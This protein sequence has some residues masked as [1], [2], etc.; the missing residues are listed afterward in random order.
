MTGFI[1]KVVLQPSEFVTAQ[2]RRSVRAE[3]G[4]VKARRCLAS[5]KM[6]W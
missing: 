4:N 6:T 2:E 1:D 5:E 3:G